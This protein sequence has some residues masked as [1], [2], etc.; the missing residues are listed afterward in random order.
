MTLLPR[1]WHGL[2]LGIALREA[3]AIHRQI[4]APVLN[5]GG[6]FHANHFLERFAPAI[7]HALLANPRQ[8][9]APKGENGQR[10]S[11]LGELLRLSGQAATG[12]RW[13]GRVL[14]REHGGISKGI[15]KEIMVVS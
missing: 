15:K 4:V 3:L 13:R 14:R 1:L 11:E 12:G 7:S 8:G 10:V 5:K 2:A 9:E 6:E